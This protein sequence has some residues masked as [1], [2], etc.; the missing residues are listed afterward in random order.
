M[1]II[2]VGEDL[3]DE[4]TGEYAGPANTT[5]PDSLN[6]YDD[7]V[8]FMHRLSD[9]EARVQAKRIQLD[10][11]IENCRKL[12]A[13]EES[14]VEWLKRKYSV[15]ATAIAYS[16]LPRKK[17]GSFASKTLTMPWGSIGFREVKPTLIVDNETAVLEWCMKNMPSAV[18][19]KE[20]ILVTPLKERFLN[21]DNELKEELPA[22]IGY[23]E[24]RQAATFTTLAGKKDS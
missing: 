7:L 3:I 4:A 5:L 24:G 6:T 22:G 17:D 15:D 9:A 1:A 20:S 11:V 10:S 21:E 23:V 19:V 2:Q 8:A 18:K 13:R 14:R 16:Q 12:L